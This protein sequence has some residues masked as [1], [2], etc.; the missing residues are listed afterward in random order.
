[1]SI[2]TA[3]VIV[4]GGGNIGS[5]VAYG[6]T[7]L[8]VSVTIIDEGDRALRSARGNF[9]LVWFQ[10]KGLGMQRYVTWCLEAT[11][12]WPGFAETLEDKT[13]LSIDYR[14]PGG[15]ELCHGQADYE[16]RR[17]ELKRLRQQDGNGKYDCELIGRRELQ[18]LL[19]R[20]K[21][22]PNILGAT[23]SPHDG[24]VNPLL[25]LR[26]MH[27]AIKLAGGRYYPGNKV[28]RIR[29]DGSVFTVE[30]RQ[31]RFSAPKLVLAAGLGIPALAGMLHLK[32]P[33]AP[34][35]G[36]ILVTERVRPI[37]PY[38]LSGIRQTGDGSF[39]FV[40]S[41]ESVGNN[42]DVTSPVIRKL[43][44]KAA[45]SFPCLSGVRVLRS[46][47]ALRPL[48]PDEFPI[49]LESEAHPGAFVLTSHSGVSLASVHA[50]HVS[51]WIVRGETPDAFHAFDLKR[52]H[53]SK[54]TSG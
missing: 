34:E 23:F 9:G 17:Q 45:Q 24:H 25:L 43:A 2:Y 26:A 37:L 21:L 38:P 32:I 13:G 19:P 46:W 47:A 7:G 11:Q 5:A 4:I 22:G 39:M 35:R 48:T 15:L 3:D 31:D 27:A 44:S 40:A 28:T 41:N 8:G 36:Q 14:K 29:H 50:T 16:A 52:F 33:V 51:R 54:P 10:G 12:K 53:I 1:V 20:M 30:T 18:S 6:M 49:Y 42:T